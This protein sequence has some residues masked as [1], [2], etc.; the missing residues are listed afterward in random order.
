MSRPVPS[1]LDP[2]DV[3]L[4]AFSPGP[5]S[6]ATAL[7]IAAHQ[8]RIADARAA[9]PVEKRSGVDRRSGDRRF[10]TMQDKL[11]AQFD[12]QLDRRF[13]SGPRLTDYGPFGD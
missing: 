13:A 12:A 9:R 5:M 4:R 8:K 2:L 1:R 6:D 3:R 7:A 10:A 11:A